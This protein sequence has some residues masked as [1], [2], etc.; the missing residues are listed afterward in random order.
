MRVVAGR[1][2]MAG[3]VET[4]G[5]ARKVDKSTVSGGAQFYVQLSGSYAAPGPATQNPFVIFRQ[6]T[7]N[8][9]VFC[10]TACAVGG[11]GGASVRS[12]LNFRIR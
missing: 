12:H 5:E 8:G 9:G 1:V 3:R 7:V 4:D 10:G 11:I 2:P 6:V